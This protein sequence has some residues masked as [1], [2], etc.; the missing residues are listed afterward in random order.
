MAKATFGDSLDIR[1]I[2]GKRFRFAPTV[3][4]LADLQ[5]AP[6]V[7][8]LSEVLEGAPAEV[9]AKAVS[10]AKAKHDAEEDARIAQVQADHDKIRKNGKSMEGAKVTRWQTTNRG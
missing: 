7:D 10:M 5:R 4:E 3:A 9:V 1:F 6:F 8:L 2:D